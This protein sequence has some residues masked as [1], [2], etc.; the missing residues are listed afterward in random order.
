MRRVAM[1]GAGMTQFGAPFG[2][3]NLA[4]NGIGALIPLIEA[5]VIT[6]FGAPVVPPV[7]K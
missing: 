5:M 1:V 7:W 4:Q 2:P 6:P 3:T